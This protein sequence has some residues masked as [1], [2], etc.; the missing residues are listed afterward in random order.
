MAGGGRAA[1]SGSRGGGL[2][3][4]RRVRLRPPLAAWRSGAQI[5]GRA[6]SFSNDDE[7]VRD[8]SRQLVRLGGMGWR[9]SL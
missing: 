4:W 9:S 8:T 5:Q 7:Q 6:A 3:W 1:W 2:G